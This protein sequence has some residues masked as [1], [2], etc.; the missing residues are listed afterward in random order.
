MNQSY[1]RCVMSE[2][3]DYSQEQFIKKLQNQEEHPIVPPQ[4]E[5]EI[6]LGSEPWSNVHEFLNKLVLSNMFHSLFIEYKYI[7]RKTIPK[8]LNLRR[9]EEPLTLKEKYW[10]REQITRSQIANL[11][12]RLITLNSINI[13]VMFRRIEI[14]LPVGAIKLREDNF[15]S[16]LECSLFG[17][18]LSLFSKNAQPDKEEQIILS[19][20]KFEIYSDDNTKR[21]GDD[22]ESTISRLTRISSTDTFWKDSLR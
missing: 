7:K 8:S 12:N 21:L 10:S 22:R 17:L 16:L 14:V 18:N 6:E 5:T 11:N 4:Q 1:A 19:H 20:N 2:W 3:T 13:P 9:N 15:I